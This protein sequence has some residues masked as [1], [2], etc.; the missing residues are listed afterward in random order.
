MTGGVLPHFTRATEEEINSKHWWLGVITDS[1][2]KQFKEAGSGVKT[3]RAGEGRPFK[4][5]EIGEGEFTGGG[6][7]LRCSGDSNSLSK[8]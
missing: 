5:G 7:L 1:Q 3:S 6:E 2:F 4:Q 8:T